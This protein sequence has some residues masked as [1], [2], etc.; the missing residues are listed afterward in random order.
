MLNRILVIFQFFEKVILT[1]PVVPPWAGY[2]LIAVQT[3]Y[4]C[5]DTIVSSSKLSTF[6]I[7]VAVFTILCLINL[8]LTLY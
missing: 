7:Y 3:P 6:P 4:F 2:V 5:L 8:K 1:G